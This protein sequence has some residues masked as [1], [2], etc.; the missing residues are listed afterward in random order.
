MANKTAEELIVELQG[1]HGRLA[2]AEGILRANRQGQVEAQA[3]AESQRDQSYPPKSPQQLQLLQTLLDALPSPVFY[4]NLEGVFLG[5]NQAFAQMVG[6]SKEGVVGKT[7]SDLAPPDLATACRQKDLALLAQEGVQ[8]YEGSVVF[9][10]GRWHPVIIRKAAFAGADGLPAGFI[11]VVTDIS[12]RQEAEA[13]HARLAAIVTGTDDAITGKTLEGI[14]TDWNP[15]AEK[16]YGYAAAEIQGKSVMVLAPPEQQGEISQI[17]EKVK[18]GEGTEHLSTVRVRKDGTRIQVSVTVSPIRDGGGTVVGAS[19][20]ARDITGLN[21]TQ[22]ALRVSLRFLEIVH[23]QTEINTLL[24][25]FVSEIK[26]FTAC[27]AVGIRVLDA[28]GGIPYL[29]YQGFSRQ[30]YEMESPLSIHSDQCMCINVIKGI[31]DHTLPFYTPGGS[32]YMNGTTRFLATVSEEDKGSTRNICNQA[33][34]ESV[35]LVPFRRG[36]QILGLIQVA[37]HREDMVPLHIVEILEKVGMQL[38]TAFQKLQAEK[39]LRE[40][41]THYRS[42]FENMLNGVAY[43]QMF[44]EEDRPKDFLYL[45]VNHAFETLTG[46][47]NVTG[48]R[49]SEVI[50]GL[51]ESDPELFEIFGRVAQTGTPERFE[52]FVEALKMWFS[53]SVYSPRQEYFVTVLDAITE[54]KQMESELRVAAQRWQI[55]FDAINDAICLIDRDLKMVRCN[56]AM[57]NLVGKPWTEIVGHTCWEVL[58]DNH[59]PIPL[60][61]IARMQKTHQHESL[62]MPLGDRWLKFNVDPILDDSGQIEG[63]VF[64]ISDVTERQRATEKI[65]NLNTL[66]QAI[67]NINE[68]LLRVKDEKELFQQTC[69]LL[70]M[71]PYVRFTWIGLVQPDSFEVKPIAWAGHEDGYLSEIKVTWD[72]SPHGAGP[73]RHGHQNRATRIVEDIENDPIFQPWRQKAQ[74]RGYASC[75]AFPLIDESTTLG[76]LNVYAEKKNAFR[77]EE[78]EFLEQVAGDIAVGVKSLRLE[79]EVVQSLIKFQVIMIQTVE[80]IASMAEMRDPYTAGH[81]RGVTRLALALARKLG[82]AVDRIE[83]LRV[84]GFLHDIG[85]IIIPAEILN[86]PGKLNEYELNLIKTH[87]QAGYDILQKIDFPWPVAQIVLQHHERLD[88]S[89]YPQGLTGSNIL[90]EARILAVADVMEAMASHRPYR[91]GLGVEKALEEITRNQG[92]LYDPQVVEACVKLFN[93]NEF[94]FSEETI[95]SRG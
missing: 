10:D 86:K 81:Q 57:L 19:T 13:E 6:L 90:L 42:L 75:I 94:H 46:L 84:A 71:V 22:D 24:E 83:G 55:T 93:R 87:S 51:K 80:A 64:I 4:K 28:G 2:E 31:C 41:E 89:G 92:T 58:L 48:K 40:S 74:Q 32:F 54:R 66:L 59:E 3:M 60:C 53:I 15:A 25:A 9:A 20:I 65:N 85:K 26:H 12:K 44:F 7:T 21:R 47:S 68:A 76:S 34:F 14:V 62:L 95:G 63:A 50:P 79:Q 77:A 91:P 33:G 1:L 27:E 5:C 17:L 23:K 70:G 8:E 88:G 36:G 18:R 38:G 67:K 82:L 72:D 78:L 30:F 35:A 11:G 16:L 37:D 73:H 29:A 69:N 52:K 61:P 43:C 49:V 45:S 39:S 56:Q